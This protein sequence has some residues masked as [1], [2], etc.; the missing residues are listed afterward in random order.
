MDWIAIAGH[1]SKAD[2]IVGTNRLAQGLDHSDRKVLEEQHLQRQ[3]HHQSPVAAG[4]RQR[5]HSTP[6]S[7]TLA[8]ASTVKMPITVWVPTVSISS[9]PA[10]GASACTMRLGKASRPI[11]RGNR[12]GPNRVKGKVPRPIQDTPYPAP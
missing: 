12:T 6:T 5:H 10:E 9:A 1:G 4:A 8:N 3:D 2:H 11:N 7:N